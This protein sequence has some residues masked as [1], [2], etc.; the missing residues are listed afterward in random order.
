M[1]KGYTLIE[2]LI[3]AGIVSTMLSAFLPFLAASN[4][5]SLH[6]IDETLAAQS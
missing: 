3:Y 2:A 5:L 4:E 1:A 6:I